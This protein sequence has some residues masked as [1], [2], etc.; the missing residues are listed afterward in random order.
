MNLLECRLLLGPVH[1]HPRPPRRDVLA[2]TV[3]D[4]PDRGRGLAHDLGDLV[5]WRLEHLVQHEHGPLGWTK[6][7]QHGEHGDRDVLGQL[8]VLGHIGTGQQRLGQPFPDVLLPPAG[9]RS[10]PVQRLPGDDPDQIGPRVTHLRLVHV[11]PPQPGLLD[12]V[13]G[14]GR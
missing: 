2:G 4:L 12:D 14:V 8:G 3:R 11:G 7:L 10:E 5:V 6:G 9:H 1:L 13:L